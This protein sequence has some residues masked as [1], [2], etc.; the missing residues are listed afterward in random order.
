MWEAFI[1]CGDW[2]DKLNFIPQNKTEP[3]R[4]KAVNCEASLYRELESRIARIRRVTYWKQIEMNGVI[5]ESETKLTYEQGSLN[6]SN[7][8]K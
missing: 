3:C 2:C 7:N 1:F 5:W 6:K 8:S 4:S